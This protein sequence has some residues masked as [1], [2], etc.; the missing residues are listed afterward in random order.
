[1]II[2]FKM[3]HDRIICYMPMADFQVHISPLG[4]FLV[5]VFFPYA[6]HEDVPFNRKVS[7]MMR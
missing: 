4:V 2:L 7:I 3:Y 5:S 6:I 1:M